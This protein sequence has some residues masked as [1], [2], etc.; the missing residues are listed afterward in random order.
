MFHE[1]GHPLNGPPL[2]TGNFVV[3]WLIGN[4]VWRLRPRSKVCGPRRLCLRPYTIGAARAGGCWAARRTGAVSRSCV[5]DVLRP[6]F[7]TWCR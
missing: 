2:C 4:V 3:W 5:R 6:S 1:G 7:P